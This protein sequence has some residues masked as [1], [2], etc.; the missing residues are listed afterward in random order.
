MP[1]IGALL[2]SSVFIVVLYLLVCF[3]RYM[4]GIPLR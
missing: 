1:F 3:L 2:G 4:S